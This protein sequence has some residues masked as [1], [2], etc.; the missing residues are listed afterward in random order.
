MAD[1][2]HVYFVNEVGASRDSAADCSEI[3]SVHIGEK[4]Y[5][6]LSDAD[7][8]RLQAAACGAGEFDGPTPPSPK[9]R[10]SAMADSLISA[11]LEMLRQ[12]DR[13]LDQRPEFRSAV[14]RLHSAV[15]QSAAQQRDAQLAAA[16][17]RL[18]F[19]PQLRAVD[20]DLTGGQS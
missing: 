7:A 12:A 10:E 14:S 1:A 6:P 3:L 18:N 16:P 8:L 4:V 17:V 19:L 20:V 15:S 5:W 2:K 9:R 13:S 11:A